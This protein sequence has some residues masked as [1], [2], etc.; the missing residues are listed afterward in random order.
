MKRNL[1]KV[2]LVLF[3][4]V[5]SIIFLCE[6]FGKFFIK[7]NTDYKKIIKSE[8][9]DPD[10]TRVASVSTFVS[11]CDSLYG[12][13]HIRSLDS[14]KYAVIISQVLR[15]R[16][17]HGY[18]YY[19]MGQNA[20]GYIMA[21]LIKSDLS[22]IV[23]PDDILKHPMAACSQQSI[24][25]MEVFRKKG[26]NV[27]KVTFFAKEYGG[28]FCF[29]VFFNNKWHYFDP[30]MEPKL[31]L[32]IANH[33]PS[34]SEITENDTLLHKLYYKL[35]NQY[36]EKLFRAY[37]YGP[38]NKFPAP[39]AIVYQY[40]TKYLSLGSWLIFMLI[41]WGLNKRWNKS[42]KEEVC[43]ELQGSLIPGKRA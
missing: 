20:L 4:A 25:G 2:L 15:Q 33:L 36:A 3:A 29:E 24:V 23:I 13:D 11:Y 35:D 7:E 14:E 22:A 19:S 9:F 27:R 26:F 10:L 1:L 42:K 40:I 34:I 39:H 6:L 37:F 8:Y 12:D 17:Y 32:M 21:P 16:F 41:Y 38:V 5:G 18:S 43:A 31:S 30:D 28:H